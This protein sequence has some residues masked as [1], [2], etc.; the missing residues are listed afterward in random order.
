M[1]MQTFPLYARS[2]EEA[3]SFQFKVIE[4]ART[5]LIGEDVLSLGDLG[6]PLGTGRPCRTEAVERVYAAAFDAEDAVFIRGAGTGALRWALSAALPVGGR[7]LVHDAPIYPTTEVTLE[8]MGAKPVFADFNSD[9]AIKEACEGHRGE[10]DCAL[11]QIARQKPSDSY[12]AAHVIELIRSLVPGVPIVADD[13]YTVG[14]VRGIGC[15]IGADLSTF[16]CFKLLGPEGVGVVVGSSELVGRIRSKQYSGGS[17]VQGH[18]AMEA[19]RGM[20][21]A[22]VAHAITAKVCAEVA[23]RLNEGEVPGVAH[24]YVVNAE[25]RVVIVEFDDDIAG[26]VLETAPKIGAAT[27]PVGCESKYEF[28]PMFYRI[29]GT[30]R[31]ADPTWERR[32]IRI[33]VM[34]AGADTVIDMLSEALGIVRANS[35]APKE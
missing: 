23:G 24:A 1:T 27:H 32:M 19:L 3:T 35:A 29:S 31:A 11:V 26:K 28:L 12:E 22:P 16:S 10:I 7:V 34:R 2:V 30:F 25:S 20:V 21:Y 9:D 13:N 8:S 14:K 15:E 18:E 33:N 4:A 17:Q 6:V 5:Q